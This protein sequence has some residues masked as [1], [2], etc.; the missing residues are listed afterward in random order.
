MFEIWSS[1][2]PFPLEN[3]T[4]RPQLIQTVFCGSISLQL[5]WQWRWGHQ[6]AKAQIYLEGMEG[7]W[8]GFTVKEKK[9]LCS[10]WPSFVEIEERNV[11][12]ER[13]VHTGKLFDNPAVTE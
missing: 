12:L 6:L 2:S 7:D 13:N 10:L 4:S 3:E 8:V 9:I 1:Q 5:P 11:V